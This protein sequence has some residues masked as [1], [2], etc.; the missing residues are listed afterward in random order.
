MHARLRMKS[1][2]GHHVLICQRNELCVE[3]TEEYQPS[4]YLIPSLTHRNV[5]LDS[6]RILALRDHDRSALHAPTESNLTGGC[7]VLLGNP[8]HIGIVQENRLAVIFL[9]P[10]YSDASERS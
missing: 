8:H 10:T 4:Q 9:R 3:H 2:E 6:L 7:V 1:V 5:L